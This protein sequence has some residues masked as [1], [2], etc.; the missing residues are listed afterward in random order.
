MKSLYQKIQRIES[1]QNNA[2]E[3]TSL[4]KKHVK[5][6]CLEHLL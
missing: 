4:F 5:I 1:L 3:H 2:D 6:D